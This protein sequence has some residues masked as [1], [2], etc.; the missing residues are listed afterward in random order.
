MQSVFD[1]YYECSTD[2]DIL[3]NPSKSVCTVF[4]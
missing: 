3:F 4:K 2:N 1:V